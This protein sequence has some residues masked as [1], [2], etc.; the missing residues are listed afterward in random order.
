MSEAL[1]HELPVR[2]RVVLAGAL[3][4]RDIKLIHARIATALRQYPAVTLDCAGATAVDL[5]FIQLVVSARKSAQSAGK[6]IALAQPAQGALRTALVQAGMVAALDAAPV[7]DQQ[8]WI[9]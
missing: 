6:T 2:D 3:T 5:S 8:F 9:Q 1:M 4:V 7:P